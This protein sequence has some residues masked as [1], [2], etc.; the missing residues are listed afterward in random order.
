[1]QLP[2]ILKTISRTLLKHNARAIVVGGAVRDYFL[3]LPIKDYDI[4]VFGLDD[5]EQLEAILKE[6]GSVNLVGQSF[7]VLKLHYQ[8][9][10]YDFSFPRLECKV[11]KGHRGF[12]VETDGSMSFKEASA[13]RDFT[14]NAMGYDIAKKLFLDPFNAQEDVNAKLLRHINDTSFIEDPLRV[15][16]AVQFCARFGYSLAP[17]TK[18]LCI[19]MVKDGLLEELPKERVYAEFVKLL[20]KS[21]KPSVGFELMR[22]L[23]VLDYFP[24]L[25]AI[26]GTPQDKKWHPEGDVWVH[27]MLCVDVM[28]GE[29]GRDTKQNLKHMF[30]TLCHDF[31]KA[32][33]TTVEDGRIR[34]IGHEHTGVELAKSFMLRLTNEHSFIESILPLVEHHLKPSQF[35]VAKSKDKAIRKLAT[36]VNIEELVTVA[37]ADFLGRTTPEALLGKY[38]AGEWLLKKAQHLKVENRPLDNLLQGRDLMEL[39]L[40]PSP[41]FKKILNAVYALQIEGSICNKEEALEYVKNRYC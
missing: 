2:K 36:K 19:K 30:A 18:D 41:K 25:Q 32:T 1:M 15:Y 31:G 13:R 29:L 8:D 37:K 34:A 35:Y 4:E 24:E 27:T 23:A 38:E 10:E 39:E 20:L 9:E 21:P 5:V 40:I 3:K 6:F 28:A 22:E 16:R 11:G 14:V 12:E 33:A 7:G 17:E 26:I